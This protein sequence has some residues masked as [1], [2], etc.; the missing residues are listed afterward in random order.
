LLF[1]WSDAWVFAS[2]RGALDEIGGFRLASLITAG[3]MLNHSILSIAE[4]K[5]G[6]AKLAMH[7]LVEVKEK[8]IAL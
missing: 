2:L 8:N 3:D 6:L 1:A 4:I 7:G 5:Q